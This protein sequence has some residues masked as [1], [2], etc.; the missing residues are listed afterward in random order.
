MAQDLAFDV[1]DGTGNWVKQDDVFPFGVPWKIETSQG[2][3]AN[4]QYRIVIVNEDLIKFRPLFVTGLFMGTPRE[5]SEDGH[6]LGIRFE[7]T[8]YKEGSYDV[9]Y[10][11]PTMSTHMDTGR[12]IQEKIPDSPVRVPFP[13]QL[14]NT[15][16]AFSAI[17]YDCITNGT[18]ISIKGFSTVDLSYGEFVNE[19][20]AFSSFQLSIISSTVS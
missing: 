13:V 12:L 2:G 1:T 16:R 3:C 10:V 8:T 14:T 18:Y 17:P 6:T 15:L 20:S 5:F 7:V 19:G 4:T 9:C 11:S